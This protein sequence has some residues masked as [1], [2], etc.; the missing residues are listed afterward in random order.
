MNY[1]DLYYG[2]F[3]SRRLIALCCL[4]SFNMLMNPKEIDCFTLPF[5]FQYSY[6]KV[7]PVFRY[8]VFLNSVMSSHSE[9]TVLFLCRVHISAIVNIRCSAKVKIPFNC[10]PSAVDPAVVRDYRCGIATQAQAYKKGGGG[11]R[12]KLMPNTFFFFSKRERGR[13]RERN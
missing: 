2:G 7:H 11:E 10:D 9:G 5:F 12:E 13:G 6:E 1:D 3:S 8:Q 4:S